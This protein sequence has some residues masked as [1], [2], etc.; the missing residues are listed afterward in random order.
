[1]SVPDVRLR[2]MGD[3]LLRKMIGVKGALRDVVFHEADREYRCWVPDDA[4]WGMVTEV[5]LL[6]TYERAGIRL[7]DSRGVVIDGGA[8]V[9][10][11][12]LR[13]AAHCSHVI[14]IEP[15]PYNFEILQKN[16][17]RNGVR[18][19]SAVCKALWTAQNPVQ[20]FDGGDS[21]SPSLLTRGTVSHQVE[22]VRL[23][24]LVSDAGRVDLLKLDIEGAEFQV[25]ETA[26]DDTLRKIGAVVVE[27]HLRGHSEAE[28]EMVERLQSVGFRV[29][30][31]DP[32]FYSWKEPM[33]RLAQNWRRSKD[34]TR[35]KL[36]VLSTYTKAA[37]VRPFF[38][39]RGR[40]NVEGLKF[41]Y[42]TRKTG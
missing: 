33:A 4:L 23:D 27:L 28:T 10:L 3:L 35:L 6:D 24:D 38:D 13:A 22:P 34:L 21:M 31:L 17:A 15:H 18:N 39:L 32:A 37:L 1:M 30:T 16:L 20:L 14:A 25:I 42:A 19:V 36:T 29:S 12:A 8:H 9:G 40:L 2:R 11:F 5:L 41:L 26:E 7:G